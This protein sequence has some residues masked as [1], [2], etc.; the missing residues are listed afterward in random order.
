MI[1][2]ADAVLLVSVYS[3]LRVG[4]YLKFYRSNLKSKIDIRD[5]VRYNLFEDNPHVLAP[6]IPAQ[7]L[8][9]LAGEEV[10]V[11][12]PVIPTRLLV[13][14][15]L[16]IRVVL[17][18]RGWAGDLMV[19]SDELTEHHAAAGGLPLLVYEGTTGIH[20]GR[21]AFTITCLTSEIIL[22]NVL[23]QPF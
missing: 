4:F 15:G 7:T 18:L 1:C 3:L 10:F 23:I 2:V 20:K 19:L 16:L 13:A 22:E 17:R 21:R 8:P 14:P 12:R 6:P 5:N 9:H 11:C